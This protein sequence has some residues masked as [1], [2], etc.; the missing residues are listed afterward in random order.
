MGVRGYCAW[1]LCAC[2]G[3]ADCGGF[4]GCMG[5]RGYCAWWLCACDGGADC[6]GF[7]V[8]SGFCSVYG[9]MNA[10]GYCV[11]GLCT[12]DW[13]ADCGGFVVCGREG[14]LRWVDVCTIVA[15]VLVVCWQSH[16]GEDALSHQSSDCP[17]SKHG[18][19]LLSTLVNMPAS[20]NCTSVPSAAMHAACSLLALRSA[21]RNTHA[22]TVCV[23]IAAPVLAVHWTLNPYALQ[24]R[25]IP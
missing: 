18:Q 13:G 2:D 6:G 23:L 5:V 9:Y 1:W 10:K 19:I 15:V 4:M 25:V 14:A 22:V 16:D 21:G 8:C 17:G 11:C 7:V 20:V 12:C 24:A 3:G